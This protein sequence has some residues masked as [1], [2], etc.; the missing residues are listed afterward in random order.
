VTRGT[1]DGF[2][3]LEQAMA[4][5]SSANSRLKKMSYEVALYRA[6]SMSIMKLVPVSFI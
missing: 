6:E 3:V 1:P 5:L 2:A 4:R